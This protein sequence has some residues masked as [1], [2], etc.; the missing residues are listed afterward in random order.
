M[1]DLQWKFLRRSGVMVS[2]SSVRCFVHLLK[3]LLKTGFVFCQLPA[4]FKVLTSF[5]WF[6][7]SGA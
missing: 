5:S 6:D 7:L 4:V 2:Q 1:F 3:S